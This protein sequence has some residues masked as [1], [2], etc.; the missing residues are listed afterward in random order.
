MKPGPAAANK[1][2]KCG[3][4]MVEKMP[5]NQMQIPKALVPRVHKENFLPAKDNNTSEFAI[6]KQKAKERENMV[7]EYMRHMDEAKRRSIFS[8]LENLVQVR[9]ALKPI[10]DNIANGGINSHNIVSMEN[11]EASSSMTSPIDVS[12]VMIPPLSKL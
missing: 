5:K 8:Q 3:P 12:G 10:D 9:V 11:G 2:Q 4:K 1:N 6:A 7:L